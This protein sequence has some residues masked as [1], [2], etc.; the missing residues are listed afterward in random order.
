[1]RKLLILIATFFIFPHSYSQTKKLLADSKIEKVTVFL[2]GAQVNRSAKVQVNPGRT[3]LVFTNISPFIDKQSLQ[4]K[5]DGKVTVLSVIH[6]LNFLKEQE[7]REEITSLDQQKNFLLEKIGIEKN[8]LNVYRQEEAMMLKN[9]DIKGEQAVLKANELKEVV[10]FHR[11]RLTEIYSKQTETERSIKK[12][13][14]ELEKLNKQLRALNEKKDQSTSE[15]IV[16]LQAKEAANVLFSL[17]YLVKKAGWYPTYDIRVKDIAS[18]I[19]FQYKANISQSS[20]EDWKEV[21][22]F[23]STGNPN[24]NGTRPFVSPWYLRYLTN[25]PSSQIPLSAFHSG[26]TP[27]TAFGRVLDEKGYPVAGASVVIK[28]STKGTTTNSDGFFSLALPEGSN[29]IVVSMVGMRTAEIKAANGY[30]NIPLTPVAKA[31]DEVVVVGYGSTGGST[32]DGAGNEDRSFKRK[33]DENAIN[34][35]TVYQP[36]TT[37]YEIEEALTILNDGKLYTADIE[38]Y[39]LKALYEYF[40]AP[41]IDASAYLTARITDWQELNLLT[42]EANLFFEG[43]FLG[44]SLLDVLNAGDTLSLSLGKDNAVVVKR[45]LMKEFSQKKFLGNNKTDTRQYELL[46][47][48]N[49]LLPITITIEDQFPISTSK[50]IEVENKQAP[51]AKVDEA[52]QKISWQ[53]IVEP[54]KEVKTIMKYSVKYPKEKRLQLD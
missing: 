9:Q 48:N 52:T 2:Q 14:A 19:N 6:Q 35:T 5:A 51:D 29:S 27:N 24:E 42:G 31:L 43:T 36:T 1:M 33:K 8:M 37:L 28:G 12:L 54:K 45:I 49:K 50:E 47:R 13:E 7:A 41:K 16:T 11:A 34:T 40:A 53:Y 18:P 38:Q 10:D 26:N 23:L 30:M 17:S 25:L 39:E 20:G 44:K 21:K 22:L 4:L 3:E 46:V 15:V 32:Y